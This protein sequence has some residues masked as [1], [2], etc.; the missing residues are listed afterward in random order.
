[1]HSVLLQAVLR[2][3]SREVLDLIEVLT[4][5]DATALPKLTAE[6]DPATSEGETLTS[7]LLAHLYTLHAPATL[8]WVLQEAPAPQ[9]LTWLDPCLT[10]WKRKQPGPFQKWLKQ[11]ENWLRPAE[12]DNKIWASWQL[13]G[14]TAA[15][16]EP[17]V[18]LPSLD[19]L[20]ENLAGRMENG[21]G[22]TNALIDW[23]SQSGRWSEVMGRTGSISDSSQRESI[24]LG[25]SMEWVKH[26]FTGWEIWADHQP[27][28]HR[29]LLYER[30]L[31]FPAFQIHSACTSVR[32]P[33]DKAVEAIMKVLLRPEVIEKVTAHTG[34][35]GNPMAAIH[36]VDAWLN[37]E[38]AAA[39]AWL[40]TQ[41]YGPWQDGLKRQQA[42]RLSSEDP[43]AA[44]AL[45]AGIHDSGTR[46]K[47]MQQIHDFWL[48]QESAAAEAHA[49]DFYPALLGQ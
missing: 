13:N 42:D 28:D 3:K 24:Q 38:A 39:S 21:Q 1:M 32:Q 45:A 43:A 46:K 34:N 25:V 9:L 23:A 12:P 29:T 44:L 5:G 31:H 17:P 4:W 7:I 30:S 16:A 20:F 41:P 19:A 15:A 27:A 8:E 6:S 10:H 33:P 2:G 48:S 37:H 11:H 47:V 14:I 26:D 35:L 49:A 18:S 22:G 40:A 36:L